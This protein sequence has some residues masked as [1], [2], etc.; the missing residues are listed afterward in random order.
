MFAILAAAASAASRQT[1]APPI[2][3]EPALIASTVNALGAVITREYIDPDV[4]SAL[5][6]RLKQALADGRYNAA[7]TADALAGMLTRDLYEGSHDKHLAVGVIRETPPA[8]GESTESRD[9]AR[10]R[11]VRRTNAG[12]RK[13]EILPGNVGYFELTNFFRPEEAR[14]ALAAAMHTLSRADA[15]IFDMRRNGGGSPGT[16]TFLASYLFDTP[17]LPLFDIV[18]RPPE[19]VDHYA[20]EST[21]PPERDARRPVFVLTSKNTF[22]G[23]EGLPFL[24]QARHRAEVIGEVTAGAA[25]PGQPYPVNARFT[26][27]VPNGRIVSAVGGGNWEGAGV[28]PDVKTTAAEAFDVAYARAL[29]L[30]IEREPAGAWRDTLERALRTLPAVARGM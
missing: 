14:D 7:T 19:P 29:R 2:A 21:V 8:P 18:H 9:R 5:D 30:L 28:T 4:A 23:G 11:A 27:T 15:L 22:S 16:I 24:L 12:V 17:Q 26:V 6:A 10:A 1:A 3:I 20:T 25:N 13:I